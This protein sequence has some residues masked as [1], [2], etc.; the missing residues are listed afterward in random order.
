VVVGND[1]AFN[2]YKEMGFEEFTQSYGN[3]SGIEGQ[4]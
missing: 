2:L 3:Y 4:S 1:P